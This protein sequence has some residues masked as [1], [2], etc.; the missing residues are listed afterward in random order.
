MTTTKAAAKLGCEL[1]ELER[2]IKP[3]TYCNEKLSRLLVDPRTISPSSEATKK[4]TAT[5]IGRQQA[6][7]YSQVLR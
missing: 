4:P 2:R 3:P 5:K 1:G 6:R 7:V